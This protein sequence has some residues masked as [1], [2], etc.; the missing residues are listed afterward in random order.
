MYCMFTSV[1]VD[2]QLIL[3]KMRQLF[4]CS[5]VALDLDTLR[6]NCV[7]QACA[8]CNVLCAEGATKEDGMHQNLDVLECA[9]DHL[10]QINSVTLMAGT[11]AYQC[12]PHL[13]SISV[14]AILT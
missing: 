8:H 3:V 1:H 5:P 12:S 13:V 7:W 6:V 4:Q 2:E 14:V 9:V 11:V 10:L